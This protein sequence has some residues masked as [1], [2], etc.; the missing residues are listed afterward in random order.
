MFA[1]SRK[2]KLLAGAAAL[3]AVIGLG[4]QQHGRAGETLKAAATTPP[5]LIRPA[6]TRDDVQAWILGA[7]HGD[8][9]SNGTSNAGPGGAPPAPRRQ[10]EA[11]PRA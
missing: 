2:T 3:L 10:A 9:P 7:V 1:S 8:T 11:D 4:P 6:Q 5:A